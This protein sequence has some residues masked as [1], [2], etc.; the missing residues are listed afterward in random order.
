MWIPESLPVQLQKLRKGRALSQ[1]QLAV[2]AQ[3]LQSRISDFERGLRRPNEAHLRALASALGA[4]LPDLIR[5]TRWQPPERGRPP[6][7][8]ETAL[9]DLFVPDRDEIYVPPRKKDF[10]FHMA[11]VRERFAEVMAVLEPRFDALPD[12][13]AAELF[14]GELPVDSAD[15]AVFDIHL[16]AFG[17]SRAWLAPTALSFAAHAVIDPESRRVVG[18]RRRPTIGAQ[19]ERAAFAVVPQVAVRPAETAIMDRLVGVREGTTSWIDLEVDGGHDSRR[20]EQRT[21]AVGLPVLRLTTEM[22]HDAQLI[23]KVLQTLLWMH[24]NSFRGVVRQ[25]R[26]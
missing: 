10:A 21:A 3:V 25:L 20:D 15:E 22:L 5:R 13:L 7:D 23:P 4:D 2:Q 26:S 8:Q 19:W 11:A 17:T 16:A 14:L 6:C 9:L 1:R 24:R 18:H 12:R